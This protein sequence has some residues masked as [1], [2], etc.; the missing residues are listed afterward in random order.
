MKQGNLSKTNEST[1][2]RL[3][4]AIVKT[5]IILIVG[6]L[7]PLFD[8]TI[9]N[10]ALH[11]LSSSLHASISTIQ[12]IMTGYLLAMGMIIPITGWSA[13]RLGN[14]RMWMIGLVLFLIGSVLSG[15]SWNIASLITFRV[16]QGLGGGIMIP[17]LTTMIM[18][19][20]GG[21]KL[22]SL[23]SIISL[24]ALLG[25]ILGPVLGGVIVNDLSWRW[26]FYVNVPICI[27]ALILAWVGLPADKPVQQRQKLD[28][29]G[30]ALLSPALVALLYSL[31]Q[32]GSQGG[33]AK[34]DVIL[35]LIIGAILLIAFIVYALTI[36][37]APLVDLRLFR[38]RSFT[39]ASILLFLTGLATYGAM[40][41]LPLY[42]QQI[43][44]ESVL[45]TGLML[46]PQGVGSLL[47]RGLA[48]KLSD[49]HGPRLVVLL[50]S[51]LCVI[52]TLPFAMVGPHTNLVLLGAALIVRGM[53]LSGVT[54]AVMSSAFQGLRREDIPH[55]S[56]ATRIA[57]QIGGAFG[58][59]V[60]AVVLDH[61]LSSHGMS[62]IAAQSS[63]FDN[64]FWWSIGFTI[65]AFLFAFLLPGN[66]RGSN[67]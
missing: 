41:L 23:M 30:F 50:S 8:T 38:V 11:S 18:Q 4:P 59:A 43:G 61:Q 1:R 34:W 52:G 35:P 17:M 63:A 55:A 21:R 56:T 40:L 28:I 42:Y 6:G 16:L 19:A 3:D 26:I 13:G 39:G 31:G 14:K 33:F 51:A 29:I 47:S 66:K 58:A 65:L 57:Q 53:G 7:A 60:F 5:A 32:V 2:E 27:A 22:G 54:I 64:T 15:L 44:G 48:G 62:G 25:P 24:P 37:S 67:G 45:T 9:M 36:P 10:V 20:A 46:I 49:H 12:W